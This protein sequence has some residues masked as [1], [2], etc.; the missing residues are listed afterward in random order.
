MGL[1]A[2]VYRHPEMYRRECERILSRA[3]QPVCHVSQIPEPGQYCRLDFLG[4]PLVV[5]RGEEGE[6][7]G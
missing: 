5:V 1:P 4:T 7:R 2:W 3:W 6:V